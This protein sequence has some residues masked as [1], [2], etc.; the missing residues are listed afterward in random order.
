MMNCTQLIVH[1]VS[2]KQGCQVLATETLFLNKLNSVLKRIKNFILL[3]KLLQTKKRANYIKSKIFRQTDQK[4]ARFVTF[5]LRKANLAT[6][7]SKSYLLLLNPSPRAQW[8]DFHGPFVSERWG[9]GGGEEAG[10]RRREGKKNPD[11]QN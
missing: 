11:S 4:K 9:G 1:L 7:V 6:L 10:G 8:K 2:S 3:Y 5:G